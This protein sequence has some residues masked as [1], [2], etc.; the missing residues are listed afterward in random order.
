[1][2]SSNKVLVVTID[3]PSGA[4]K[5]T[6]A[7]MVAE[8]TGF[9][10]LDSGALYRLT[11]LACVMQQIDLNDSDKTAVVARNLDVEFKTSESGVE[12]WLSGNNV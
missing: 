12:V 8:K 3:G 1:M 10:L 7:R 5:G 2:A 9:G 6:I 11:G 4:G